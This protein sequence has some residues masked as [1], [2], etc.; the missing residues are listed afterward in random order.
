MVNPVNNLA[1][2]IAMP[3][4]LVGGFVIVVFMALNPTGLNL[5]FY[6]IMSLLGV[7]VFFYGVASGQRM[8]SPVKKLLKRALELSGGDLTARVYL[9]SKDE[10]EELAKLFNK[11]AE[12]L[13][14]SR[15]EATES[16][17]TVGVKVKART[18]ALEETIDALEQKVRNRTA[19]LDKL[20]QES[21]GLQQEV[22]NKGNEITALRKELEVLK[23]KINKTKS[24]KKNTKI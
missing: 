2:K 9:E 18:Q 11:I 19:E 1:V 7:F 24:S 13:E 23:P 6:I 10:F 12:E 14:K 5:S 22:Q 4:I 8:A 15:A 21:G 16:E 20:M 17:K 3:M